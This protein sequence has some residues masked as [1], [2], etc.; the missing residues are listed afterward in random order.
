MA[1]KT[2]KYKNEWSYTSTPLVRLHS[3]DREKFTYVGKWLYVWRSSLHPY[4]IPTPKV[5]EMTRRI[6][7]K[8]HATGAYFVILSFRPLIIRTWRPC[9]LLR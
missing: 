7:H 5:T 2:I 9:E 4:A 6:L 8:Y 3:V 1:I